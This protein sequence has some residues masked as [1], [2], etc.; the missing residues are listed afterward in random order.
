MIIVHSGLAIDTEL[1]TASNS[2]GKRLTTKRRFEFPCTKCSNVYE[3][4]LARE[5]KKKHKWHCKSCAISFEW[6]DDNYRKRHVV[7]IVLAKSTEVSKEKHSQAQKRKY[8]DPIFKEKV[9]NSLRTVWNSKEY[10]SNLSESLKKRWQSHPLPDCASRK[11]AIQ[12]PAGKITVKSSYEKNF[13]TLL[14]AYGYTWEYE[15][16][17]FVLKSLDDRVLVPDFYVKDLDLIVEIKGYFWHDAKE[18]WEAFDQE[19]PD[20]KKLILFKDDLQKLI[21][22]EDTLENRLEKISGKA[23]RL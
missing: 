17:A 6:K 5:K 21:T 12:T 3:T 19:Y 11:Y 16:K 13:I 14:N 1:L 4:T 9:T 23:T 7:A 20:V 18:K 8:A 22:G 2:S 15:T 10:R